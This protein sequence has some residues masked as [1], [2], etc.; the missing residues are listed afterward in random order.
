MTRRSPTSVPDASIAPTGSSTTPWAP[1]TYQTMPVH[2]RRALRRATT[3]REPSGSGRPTNTTSIGNRMN[4]MW[5]PLLSGS[6]SPS[7]EASAARPMR[8][9]NLPH[10][11][12]ATSSRSASRA[13]L[14]RF[15]AGSPARTRAAVKAGVLLGAAGTAEV[16]GDEDDGGAQDD[17]EERREDAADEREEHLDRRLRGHLLGALPALDAKL[18]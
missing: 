1:R 14:V 4:I 8:P 16:E 15:R 10:R 13:P 9:R 7:P 5:M 6:H 18:L 12:A 11:P 3:W 2:G 17:D